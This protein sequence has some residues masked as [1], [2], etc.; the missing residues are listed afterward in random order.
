MK[1]EKRVA[2][3][4]LENPFLDLL[5]EETDFLPEFC[6]YRDE[7]CEFSPS[8]LSCPQPRC[9][10]EGAGVRPRKAKQKRNREILRLF[11]S[12]KKNV[13]EL[14]LRFRISQR[15]VQMVVASIR[16]NQRPTT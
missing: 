9:V 11:T 8:C 12:Q 5:D 13:K 15:T 16:K 10:F 14:A 7:G 6:H 2:I 1:T 4:E 3:P